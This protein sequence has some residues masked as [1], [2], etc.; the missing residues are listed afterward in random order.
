MLV[1]NEVKE[2]EMIIETNKFDKISSAAS[3]LA[4]YYAQI[5]KI[6]KEELVKKIESFFIL[7]HENVIGWN[8]FIS[9]I[10][11]NA[12]KIP[13]CQIDS[14]PIT[15][16]EIDIIK[17]LNSDKKEKIL[18]TF[19][20]FGKLKYMRT[21]KAWVNDTS[22]SMFERANTSPRADERDYI[23][24]DFK[25]AEFIS[26]A[27]SP[28]NLSIHIDF[29]DN[30]GESVFNVSDL[31]NLGF[32]WMKYKGG[33]YV[34]CNGCGILFKPTQMNNCYCKD[35]RGYIPL[36]TKVVECIDCGISFETSSNTK[37]KRC[38]KCR[39]KHRLEYQKNLMASIRNS[40]IC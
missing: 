30:D 1:I 5:K 20:V 28:M 6:S 25:E 8:S 10:I 37:S 11:K 12:N 9:K 29:I 33:N 23:I 7:N 32:K 40:S 35:C 13:L 34:E 36:V 27:K 16:K 17:S 4:R 39:K 21:G 22:K 38:Y 19:L 14:I 26:Y 24:R 3:L 15:Q 18:F 31:R 2:A